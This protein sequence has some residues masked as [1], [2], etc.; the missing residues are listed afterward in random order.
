VVTWTSHAFRLS[1]ND[2]K[3]KTLCVRVRRYQSG[4]FEELYHEHV[5]AYRLS[6]PKSIEMMKAMVLRFSGCG[7]Y[8][9]LRSY[10]NTRSME[11]AAYPFQ[12]TVE[13]PEPGVLRTYCGTSVQVWCDSVISP[14]NFRTPSTRASECR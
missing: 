5:P 11:P 2:L 13:Y 6:R 1:C 8:E 14:V 3:P 7:A 12:I 4:K 10:L 9:V